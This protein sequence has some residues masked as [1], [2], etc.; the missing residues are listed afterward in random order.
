M[1]PH[2]HLTPRC[3]GRIGTFA[4]TALVL[5][6]FGSLL[7]AS[8]AAASDF[9]WSGEGSA[10]ANGWS[11]GTNWTGGAAPASG[12]SIGTLSFPVLGRSA[13][14][15][16]TP[17]EA[18]ETAVNDLTG[19]AVNELQVDDADQY[20]LS[21]N[22]FTLGAG[23]LSTTN[24]VGSGGFA[25]IATP[26]TLGTGQTWSVSGGGDGVSVTGALSGATAALTVNLPAGASLALGGYTASTTDS[27]VG[28]VLVQ[29][30]G[31]FWLDAP[32][33]ATDGHSVTVQSGQ[34]FTSGATVG[35]LEVLGSTTMI[36]WR[37][38]EAATLKTAG[39]VFSGG[40]L[41]IPITGTGTQSG[42]DYSQLLS[43]GNVELSGVTLNVSDNFVGGCPA[44]PA[45]QTDVLVSTTGSLGGTFVNAPNGS[46]ITTQ[47][48]SAQYTPVEGEKFR[49]EYNTTGS[50]QT[51]TATAI[52][53]GGGSAPV[54]SA[55][56]TL[57]GS[58]VEGQALTEAHGSWSN[59]PT[60]YVYQWQDCDSSGNNCVSI[61]GATGQTYTLTSADVGHTVRVQETASNANGVGAPATSAQTAM[62]QAVS[63]GS[64]G[65]TGGG[66]TSSGSGGG[67]GASGGISAEQVKASLMNQLVPHGKTAK[68]T[69]L[70]KHG[71]YALSFTALEAG[72]VVVQWYLLPHGAVLAKHGKGHSKPKPILVASGKAT[73][74]GAGRS[75]IRLK[76]TAAGKRL[77]GH[78]KRLTLTARADFKSASGTNVSVTRLFTA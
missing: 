57:S 2:A 11:N 26:I 7:L 49:I 56:P 43:A 55:P 63:S 46:T 16:A 3:R 61:A 1:Q 33:N 62:V 42:S 71:G 48:L 32:L 37:A 6:G 35:A 27:E 58:A 23:G 21:G 38:S 60:S 5:A 40:A 68:I 8:A 34:F 10:S 77:L 4:L 44:V 12:A 59:S 39:A 24:H 72:T 17:T 70:L 67:A 31:D 73:L 13:C 9:S 51:V 45:G 22:S 41:D 15:A 30:G 54:N 52:G 76:L 20:R 69:A 78:S 74:A 53:G 36:G 18:C 14:F 66:G 75:T 64:S 65:T 29:G 25:V 19:L 28:N 50:P 47:C